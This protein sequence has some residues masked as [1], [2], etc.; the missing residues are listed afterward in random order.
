MAVDVHS[1]RFRFFHL[2]TW[3]DNK[4]QLEE[5]GPEKAFEVM[6]GNGELW[7]TDTRQ[8]SVHT[9]QRAT[10]QVDDPSKVE[11]FWFEEKIAKLDAEK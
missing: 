3:G 1:N 11:R 6:N 2:H 7:F 9:P 10:V 5:I 4:G 8:N